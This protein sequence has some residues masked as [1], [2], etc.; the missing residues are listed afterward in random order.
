MGAYGE[1]TMRVQRA[2]G[3]GKSITESILMKK[4][5]F[6]FVGFR[7]PHIFELLAGVQEHR[8]AEV[9]ACCEEDAVMRREL[10]TGGEVRVTHDDFAT[11]LRD[12]PCDVVA[13]GD[14]YGKRGRLVMAALEA[15]KHVLGDKPL[16]TSLAEQSVIERLASEQGLLVGLQ[17]DCR[18]Y[19]AFRSLRELVRGGRIGE[20][21]TVQV[22][23]QHPL[24]LGTRA[25]WYFEKGMH[26]GTLN[27]IGIHALDFIPWITGWEWA[28]VPVAR[29]WNA[30]ASKYPHFLDCAQMM[31]RLTN[32][33]GVLA[34]FSYLAPE[35]LGYSTP[36]YWRILVHGTRGQAQTHLLSSQIEYITDESSE[37][38]VL[39]VL[40]NTPRAYLEDFLSELMGNRADLSSADALRASRMA[41]ETQARS[42]G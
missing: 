18:G 6:A 22:G 13:V 34:D 16:C 42:M 26:G 4:N 15:G 37:P 7:H 1:L 38:Q 40:P 23:G 31:G 32:G 14:C 21:C 33:A 12:V 3:D 25:A 39:D 8:Y 36:F 2:Q 9:V 19:G 24:S 5:R 41:L 28:G 35:R 17:L 30:K 29:C 27:D 20:V 11:M 10:E